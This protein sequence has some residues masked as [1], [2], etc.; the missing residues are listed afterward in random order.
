MSLLVE[1]LTVKRAGRTIVRDCSFSCAPGQAVML[2]GPNGAGKSTLLR[3]IAGFLP[4]TGT[5]S[6]NGHSLAQDKDEVQAQLAYAGHLDAI[7]P[8]LSVGENLELWADVF[9]SDRFNEVLG[10]FDLSAIAMRP[11]GACSA[12]QRRRL[13][14]ARLALVDRALWLMDEPTVSLDQEN[15]ARIEAEVARHLDEGG[16]AVIATH[17]P[18]DVPHHVLELQPVAPEVDAALLDGVF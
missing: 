4:C 1:T 8:A 12:G 11:A 2:R 5:V 3:A 17:L 14:L 16:M 10:R 13:G 18:L 15:V 6:L 9:G 7:K